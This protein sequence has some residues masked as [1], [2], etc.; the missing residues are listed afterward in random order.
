MNAV[1][2]PKDAALMYDFD[3][4]SEIEAVLYTAMIPTQPSNRGDL[5]YQVT[6]DDQEPV[7]ISLKT[8]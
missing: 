1:A 3:S 7:V 2:L 4:P 8:P 5:R 6:I